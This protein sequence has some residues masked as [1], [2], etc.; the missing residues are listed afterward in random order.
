MPLLRSNHS[1]N[2][3]SVQSESS[4]SHHKLNNPTIEFSLIYDGELNSTKKSKEKKYW[5]KQEFDSIHKCDLTGIDKSF[6][7]TF[8]QT[9]Q[10]SD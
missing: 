9:N 6:I 7:N 8:F 1:S 2:S 4:E 5:T 10:S 3:E